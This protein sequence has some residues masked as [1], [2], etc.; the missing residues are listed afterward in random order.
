[1]VSTRRRRGG[2]VGLALLVALLAA[3]AGMVQA[4]L[5]W[6]TETV[7]QEGDVGAFTSLALDSGGQPHISYLDST[8]DDL[9]YA[10]HDGAQWVTQHVDSDGNVGWYSSLVL[11]SEDQPH[12]SHSDVGNGD[13]KYAHYDGTTW[14]VEIVD[15]EGDVGVDPSLALDGD[16]QPHIVYYDDSNFDLKYAHYDGTT[17]QFETIDSAGVVGWDIGMALDSEGHPHVNYYD[18]TNSA[19]KYAH[20]TGSDWMTETLDSDG[21]VGLTTSLALDSQGEPHISYYDT[22]NGDLKYAHF[23]GSDWAIETVDSAGSVGWMTSLAL[24][25]ADRPHISYHDIGNGDLKYAYHDGTAWRIET[26]DAAG[27]VGRYTALALDSADQPRISYYDVSGD[28]LKYAHATRND[29]PIVDAGGPY[30]GSEASPI[31]LDAT[32]ADP[33]NDALITAWS[34]IIDNADDGTTCSFADPSQV[35]TTFTCTDDGTFTVTLEADDGLNPAVT[36]DTTVTVENV[37]PTIT[38]ATASA[39]H[40][41]ATVMVEASGPAGALDPLSY[42][43]DCDNS[44]DFEV[45]AGAT[46]STTCPLNP[47]QEGTFTFGFQVS[48]DDEGVT[49]DTVMVTVPTHLCAS[50][51]TG[52]LRYSEGCRDYETAITIPDDGPVTICASTHNGQLRLPTNGLCAGHET[53]YVLPE[54][55]PLSICISNYT[56][57]MRSVGDISQCTSNEFGRVIAATEVGELPPRSR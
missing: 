28:N 27:F 2:L 16:D 32:V 54:D 13:L 19:L 15:S 46:N 50:N 45:D 21:D 25:S 53:S 17:W 11:D 24:D 33:E 22:S 31:I 52:V 9:M 37:A 41:Q 3:P 26:V 18:V 8:N 7:D 14:H 55:G 34:Y 38:G 1:M 39:S 43:F 42:A 30:S 44:G 36:A 20:Y 51:I 35:A 40:S 12:I 48:D 49:T 5:I 4:V 56:Q 23:D 47:Q 29:P 10:Y 57:T 6:Q